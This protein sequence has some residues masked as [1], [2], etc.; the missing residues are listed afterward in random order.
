MLSLEA[1][2]IRRNHNWLKSLSFFFS[3]ALRSDPILDIIGDDE[4]GISATPKNIEQFIQQSLSD[5][6]NLPVT[7]QAKGGM[8]MDKGDAISS[9]RVRLDP[10]KGDAAEMAKAWSDCGTHAIPDDDFV[11]GR[12]SLLR[13]LVCNAQYDAAAI[14]DG[15]YR[16][17]ISPRA[18]KQYEQ[19]SL[20][21]A[22]GLLGQDGKDCAATTVIDE[23]TRQNLRDFIA[24]AKAAGL[25]ATNPTRQAP[26]P[27]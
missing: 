8:G 7:D 10:T 23:S 25:S 18:L 5:F 19:F 26:P 13:D 9:M 2:Q 22:N 1:L 20:N 16:I 15:I 3:P 21:L 12:I 11:S 4:T 6:P 27:Q 17:W 14:A 24:E